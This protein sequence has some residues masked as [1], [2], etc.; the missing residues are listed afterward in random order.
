[1]QWIS[2]GR[3]LSGSE[4]R[5]PPRSDVGLSEVIL[6]VRCRCC[7]DPKELR[8]DDSNNLRWTPVAQRKHRE[9]KCQLPTDSQLLTIPRRLQHLFGVFQ[10]RVGQLL[11]AYHSR[12]FFGT[13]GHFEQPH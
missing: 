13:F 12:Q 10:R 7:M 3:R 1:M 2:S 11:T 8:L 9:R 5:N 4:V 6:T